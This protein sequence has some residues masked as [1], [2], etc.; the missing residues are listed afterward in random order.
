V[1]LTCRVKR[2]RD[3]K[4]SNQSSKPDRDGMSWLLSTV[5][6]LWFRINSVLLHWAWSVII[7]I[8]TGRFELDYEDWHAFFFLSNMQ[9]SWHSL[10]QR[11]SYWFDNFNPFVLPLLGHKFFILSWHYRWW[12]FSL[13]PSLN[14][15][16]V[17]ISHISSQMYCQYGILHKFTTIAVFPS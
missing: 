10:F 15:N 1:L 14:T 6:S 7:V 12:F 13:Y 4:T 11:F 16:C 3:V 5:L 17:F 8:A 2:K 9:E